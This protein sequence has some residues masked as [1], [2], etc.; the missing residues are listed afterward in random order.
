MP[1]DPVDITVT[2]SDNGTIAKEETAIQDLRDDAAVPVIVDVQGKG[3]GLTTDDTETTTLN[4]VDD[5]DAE[6]VILNSKT[7]CLSADEGNY[8]IR[9]R[10]Y[11]GMKTYN[12][13]R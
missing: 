12:L 3:T 2:A 13:H 10:C 1:K 4:V 7:S 11:S 6:R 9:R 8:C 5:P